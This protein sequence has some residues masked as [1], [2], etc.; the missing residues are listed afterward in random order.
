MTGDYYND[1]CVRVRAF[2]T[3][4]PANTAAAGLRT[5]LS[6]SGAYN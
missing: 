2:V 4:A 3:D 6:A 5:T 1:N